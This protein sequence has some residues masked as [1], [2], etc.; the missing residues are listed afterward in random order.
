MIPLKVNAWIDE[1]VAPLVEALNE[2]PDIETLD[3]C[4]DDSGAA[5]V[6]FRFR[7]PDTAE[8]TIARTSELARMLN[9]ALVRY[10]VDIEFRGDYDPIARIATAPDS[11]QD[12]AAAIRARVVVTR[13]A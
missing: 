4:E 12:L 1:G 7:G 9:G 2:I 13:S 6:Y 10:E 5:R 8:V 3:S 11:V